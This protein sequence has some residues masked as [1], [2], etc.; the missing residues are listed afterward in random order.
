[1][2]S[3]HTEQIDDVCVCSDGRFRFRLLYRSHISI[4]IVEDEAYED[5]H[6]KKIVEYELDGILD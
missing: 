3:T 1:M 2:K 6:F 5:T 4:F